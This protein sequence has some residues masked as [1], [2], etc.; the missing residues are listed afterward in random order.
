MSQAAWE[1]AVDSA[2]EIA[3]QSGVTVQEFT[4]L[5]SDEAEQILSEASPVG[6]ESEE[7]VDRRCCC[8]PGI[9]AVECPT[10]G[11]AI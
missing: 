6:A 9:T 1:A 8:S 4:D 3:R 7:A 10:H 2:V 11:G 5:A